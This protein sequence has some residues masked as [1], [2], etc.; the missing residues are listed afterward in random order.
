VASDVAQVTRILS[1]VLTR[2]LLVLTLLFGVFSMHQVSQPSTGHDEHELGLHLCVGLVVTAVGLVALRKVSQS[3]GTSGPSRRS[4][5]L[6]PLPRVT[7]VAAE[8]PTRLVV[9]RL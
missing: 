8:V 9:L 7:P 1:R 2:S 3:D 5:R 6:V 4:F